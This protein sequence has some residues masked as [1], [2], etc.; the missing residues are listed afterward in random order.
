MCPGFYALLLYDAKYVMSFSTKR[1]MLFFVEKDVFFPPVEISKSCMQQSGNKKITEWTSATFY[2]W[3]KD[4][5]E[6]YVKSPDKDELLPQQ[7]RPIRH[8]SQVHG[9]LHTIKEDREFAKSTNG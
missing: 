5:E 6:K 7:V 1:I 4:E 8:E 2:R 9:L 3:K